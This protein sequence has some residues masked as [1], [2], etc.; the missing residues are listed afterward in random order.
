MNATNTQLK[1]QIMRRIYIIAF[2]KQIFHPVII[3]SAVLIV[4]MIVVNVFVST[5]NVIKNMTSL[6]GV[7]A[8]SR[9]L[10]EA[11]LH[12]EALVQVL[13]SGTIVLAVWL[14]IDITRKLSVF[15]SRKTQLTN[16]QITV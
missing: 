15:F 3:R 16:T 8:F 10:M 12:T 6:A 7:E 13:L 9:F 14:V 5:I 1:K 2:M 4:F 11:F